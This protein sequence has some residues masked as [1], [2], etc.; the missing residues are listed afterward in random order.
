MQELS[1]R[2][3]V[4]L[5]VRSFYAKVRKDELLGPVFNERITDWEEHLERLTDFWESNLLFARKYKGNPVQV[6]IDVDQDNAPGIDQKLFGKWLQLWYETLD[7]NFHGDNA[8]IAKN[9]ARNMA[10]HLFMRMFMA[11]VKE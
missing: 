3:A 6:H 7:A 8:Q 10:T 9:R 2:P 11:R 4:S 5:L 1:S